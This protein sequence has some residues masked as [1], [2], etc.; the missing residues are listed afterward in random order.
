MTLFAGIAF[1]HGQHVGTAYQFFDTAHTQS[2]HPLTD[3]LS[4]ESEVVLHHVFGADVVLIPQ[5]IILRGNTG[6]T[7]IEVTDTQ[8][9]TANSNHWQRTEAV[10]FST[11]NRCLDD[12]QT[13]LKTA[14]YAANGC[15]WL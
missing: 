9:L 8:V 14:I 13:A 2:R 5:F 6:R 7:V 12:I 15:C 4:H 3:F 11:Q 1:E 10:G